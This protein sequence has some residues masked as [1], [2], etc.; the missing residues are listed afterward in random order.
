MLERNV[1]VGQDAPVGHHRNDFVHVGVRVDVVQAHPDAILGQ[2]F[3][4]LGHA[5]ADR[6]ALVKPGA[7]LDVDAVGARVLGN[8]EQLAHAGR[9]EAGG[10]VQHI[11][12]WPADEIATQRGN[13]AEAAAVVAAF[14]NLQVGVVP[15]GEL[16]ALWRHQVGERIVGQGGRGGLVHGAYDLLVLLRAGD[17][18]HARVHGAN[19]FFVAAHASRDDD[20]AVLG[21]RFA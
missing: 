16:H 1:E 12:H 3:A 8:H 7:E 19:R 5:G 4:K 17:G 2:C 14:G 9:H 11:A 6:P 21:Q 13:N 20:A 15:G 18:E 10:L